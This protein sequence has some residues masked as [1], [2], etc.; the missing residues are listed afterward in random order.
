MT[1]IAN[2]HITDETVLATLREIVSEKPEYVYSCPPHMGE[3]ED[4]GSCY[5]VHTDEDGSYVSAGCAIGVVLNRLG[6][7]LEELA[8]NEGSTA[9]AILTCLAPQLSSRTKWRM[10][11]M[12]MYQ[13]HGDSWGLAYAKATGETI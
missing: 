5:Y 3:T 9:R 8:A 13:D 11:D 6:V 10:N 12:Q 2:V 4:S 1:A 7:P